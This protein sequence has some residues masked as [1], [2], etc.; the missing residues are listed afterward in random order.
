MTQFI[1]KEQMEIGKT[2]NKFVSV[3]VRLQG[4]NKFY[5]FMPSK[6]SEMMDIIYRF[7]LKN[8]IKSIEVVKEYYKLKSKWS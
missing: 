7:H 8:D 2:Y 4:E 3:V 5:E 1:T 6:K